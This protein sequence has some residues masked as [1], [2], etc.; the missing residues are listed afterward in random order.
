MGRKMGS[1]LQRG[2]TLIEVLVT[3]VVIGVLAAVVIPAVTAQVTAGDSA[4]VLQDLNNIRTGAENFEIAVRQFPGDV[5]DLVNKPGQFLSVNASTTSGGVDAD[6]AGALYTSVTTWNGPYIESSLA[7]GVTSS[8]LPNNSSAAFNSGYNANISNNFLACS[9]ATAQACSGTTP[10]YLVVQVNNLTSSQAQTV[11]D[12]I[13]GVGETTS[14]TSGKFR[15]IT[16][17]TPIA[18]YFATPYK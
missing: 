5:D 3:V 1:I 2:F 6:L 16:S 14:G 11:N 17:G 18:Y 8:T 7:V 12:L 9:I 4:R 15:A 10:D 13:D